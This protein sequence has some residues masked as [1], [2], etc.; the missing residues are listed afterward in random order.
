[1][2]Q[3]GF[4]KIMGNLTATADHLTERL[5]KTGRFEIMS[6]T[7]GRGLP[8]VAFRLKEKH[9][10]NEVRKSRTCVNATGLYLLNKNSFFVC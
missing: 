6:E 1:M 7:G 4:R 10:Y 8:L 5:V 9:A 3:A 2:G